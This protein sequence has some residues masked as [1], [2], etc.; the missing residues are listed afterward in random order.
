MSELKKGDIVELTED[1]SFTIFAGKQFTVNEDQLFSHLKRVNPTLSDMLIPISKLKKIG[2]SKMQYKESN[3][4]K[5]HEAIK[6]TGITSKDLSLEHTEGKSIYYFSNFTKK[7]HF[8]DRGDISEDLLVGLKL[9]VSFA[10]KNILGRSFKPNGCM[11]DD[12]H[13]ILVNDKPVDFKHNGVGDYTIEITKPNKETINAINSECKSDVYLT[14]K[15]LADSVEEK[16][17]NTALCV[18]VT[19]AIVL[20]LTVLV[21]NNQFGWV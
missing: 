18:S 6:K 15:D 5:L 13:K 3:R 12:Q 21:L 17:N 1:Y 20:I 11:K 4:Y 8:E 14:A 9:S 10:E 19:V 16:P 2:E 7:S